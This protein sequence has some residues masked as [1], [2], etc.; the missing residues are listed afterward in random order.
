LRSGF[1]RMCSPRARTPA[2]F[3]RPESST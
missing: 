1:A 3:S 2:R